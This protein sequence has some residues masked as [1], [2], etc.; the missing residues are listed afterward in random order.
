MVVSEKFLC[1]QR[2]TIEQIRDH[3]W[4]QKNYVPVRSFEYEDVNLD[5]VNAVFDDAD[6][7]VGRALRSYIYFFRL[8]TQLTYL[9]SMNY[10]RNKGLVSTVAM[11]TWVL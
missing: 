5:D 3:E 2:I 10:S 1:V 11:K 6:S 4:F 9:L 7:E 8:T